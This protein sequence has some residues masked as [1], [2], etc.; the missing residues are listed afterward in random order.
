MR[1]AGAGT[2]DFELVGLVL[3]LV[4]ELF[5][6][7]AVDCSAQTVLTVSTSLFRGRGSEPQHEATPRGKREV[8]DE[9]TRQILPPP[10]APPSQNGPERLPE[11]RVGSGVRDLAFSGTNADVE[12]DFESVPIS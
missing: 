9:P 7:S 3:F 5:V 4:G 10:A 11:F 6:D 12:A 1:R 2:E 8:V